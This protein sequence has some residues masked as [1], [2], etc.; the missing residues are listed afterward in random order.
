M[1]NR[2]IVEGIKGEHVFVTDVLGRVIY[3]ATV[4][5]RTEI[6]V[7]NR[8]VYFVKIGSRP[9]KKVVVAR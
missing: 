3:N 6:A 2:L 5:E 7:R 4:N 9:A 1:S 8:G